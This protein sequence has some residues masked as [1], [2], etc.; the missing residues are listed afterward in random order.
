MTARDRKTGKQETISVDASHA[1]MSEAE[2]LAARDWVEESAAALEGIVI[3]EE[4]VILLA[5]AHELLA[6]DTLKAKSRQ[7]LGS[8][9]VRIESAQAAGE[10]E[11]LEDLLD[12]L[13]DLLFDLEDDEEFINLL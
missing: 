9:L 11:N 7:A 2:I 3:P 5:H 10:T 1:R 6:S 12:T 13:E 8:L 4:S